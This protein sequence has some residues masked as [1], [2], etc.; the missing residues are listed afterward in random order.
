MQ[1]S[2]RA[3]WAHAVRLR[4]LAQERAPGRDTLAPAPFP[5]PLQLAQTPGFLS[6]VAACLRRWHDKVAIVESCCTTIS[7]IA[8]VKDYR[9]PGGIDDLMAILDR[10]A[11]IVPTCT[12]HFKRDACPMAQRECSRAWKFRCTAVALRH[13]LS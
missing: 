11:R 4:A 1:T 13:H 9:Q 5:P 8:E 3:A 2:Q 7:A 12:V 6:A 10:W